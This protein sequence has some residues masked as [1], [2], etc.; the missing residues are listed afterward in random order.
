MLLFISLFS[1]AMAEKPA[2]TQPPPKWIEWS[3]KKQKIIVEFPS[4][5]SLEYRRATTTVG[6]VEITFASSINEDKSGYVLSY[7]H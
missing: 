2:T 6:D 1:P 4:K 7:T 5:P 3:P